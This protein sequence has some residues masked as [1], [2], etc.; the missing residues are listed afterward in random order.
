[1]QNVNICARMVS[2]QR[3]IRI[4]WGNFLAF[5]KDSSNSFQML[6][7]IEKNDDE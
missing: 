2:F 4:K 7:Y 1:M 5:N 3:N 6:R